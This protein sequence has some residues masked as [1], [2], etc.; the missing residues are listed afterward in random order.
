M[1]DAAAAPREVRF[2]G[3]GGSVESWWLLTRALGRG[4]LSASI[5]ARIYFCG[6]FQLFL[7]FPSQASVF[8]L[9]CLDPCSTSP[10]PGLASALQTWENPLR[11]RAPRPPQASAFHP[12]PSPLACD[13]FF[14]LNYSPAI[15]S[16][17][18]IIPTL[19]C[20]IW[21]SVC[22][23]PLSQTFT[24]LCLDT[25]SL[26]CSPA[27]ANWRPTLSQSGLKL[28]SLAGFPPFTGPL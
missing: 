16:T 2:T 17:W 10:S 1:G 7:G 14:P 13:Y 27:L 8:Y 21:H 20:R 26:V 5:W 9:F 15:T 24:H 18:T 6:S 11:T 25:S 23:L 3:P 12:S 28:Q 19:L 4:R 22:L